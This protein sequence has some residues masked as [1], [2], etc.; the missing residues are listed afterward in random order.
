MEQE[1]ATTP[2]SSGKLLQVMQ[3]AE[4]LCSSLEFLILPDKTRILT[5]MMKHEIEVIRT[6]LRQTTSN[7]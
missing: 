7:V 6:F 1:Q 4:D 2:V 3:I 5:D